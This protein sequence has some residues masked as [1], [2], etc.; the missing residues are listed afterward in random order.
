MRDI[1]EIRVVGNDGLHKIIKADD[2]KT[3]SLN[4][5]SPEPYC[6]RQSVIV[7]YNDGMETEWMDSVIEYITSVPS[8]KPLDHG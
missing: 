7:R 3:M 6:H 1:V 2:T 8:K 4:M 5:W